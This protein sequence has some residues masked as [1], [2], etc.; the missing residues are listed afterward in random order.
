MRKF[1]LAELANIAEIAGAIV[2]VASLAYIGIEMN[3]NTKALQLGSYQAMISNMIQLDIAIAT[4]EELSRIVDT[5]E[6]KPTDLAED[7]WVR[8]QT[9]VYPRIG[10]WEYL[11]LATQ[12]NALS[13]VQWQSFQPYYAH[14]A[15]KPGY[16]RFWELQ[17]HSFSPVFQ[18][19]LES[20][21][22]PNC[23]RE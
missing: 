8:F 12:E 13:D 21:I 7:E 11:F 3:Q 14:M 9:V 20:E 2:I 6:S 17:R 5:A 23:A 16:R 18:D 1:S 10:L 19:Y 22:L 15:C 4:D